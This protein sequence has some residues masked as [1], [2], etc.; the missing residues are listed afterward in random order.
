MKLVVEES[1]GKFETTTITATW[2]YGR[3]AQPFRQCPERGFKLAN[4]LSGYE[5]DINRKR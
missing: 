1:I 2:Q 5:I 4:K 3:N